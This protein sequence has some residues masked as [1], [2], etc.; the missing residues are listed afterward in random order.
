ML[1][2]DVEYTGLEI[3]DPVSSDRPA[4]STVVGT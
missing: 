3:G 4:R 2:G 1:A